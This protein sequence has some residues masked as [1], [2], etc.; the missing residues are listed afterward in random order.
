MA[1]KNSKLRHQLLGLAIAVSVFVALIYVTLAATS[2]AV[3]S[4]SKVQ[5]SGEQACHDAFGDNWSYAEYIGAHPPS[6]HCEGPNGQTGIAPMP[7]EMM[8]KLNI[9]TPTEGGDG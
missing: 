7:D 2:G 5:Q 9:V 8:Q 1:D 4:N 6:I 3:H